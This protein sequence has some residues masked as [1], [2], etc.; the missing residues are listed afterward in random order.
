MTFYFYDLET[1]GLNPFADRIMQ[2]GGQKVNTDLEPLGDL[3]EFYVKLSDD[4]LPG[5]QAIMLHQI[6]PQTA[7][8]EGLSEVQFLKWL[9]ENV[10]ESKTIFAGYN[11]LNFDNQFMRWLHWRNFAPEAPMKSSGRSLDIYALMRLASDLR[12]EGLNWPINEKTQQPILVL[13]T[14]A[15][16]NKIDTSQSHLAGSDVVITL[17]LG[18]LI[19]KAQ[20]KLFEHYL[21]LLQPDFVKQILNHQS[22]VFTYS[23]PFNLAWGA[24]TTLATVL[25]EHPTKVNHYIIYDLR[26]DPQKWVTLDSYNLDLTL[27]NRGYPQREAS[28]FQIIDINQATGDFTR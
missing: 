8:L 11:I 13:S 19:K 25:A 18:R 20:P 24:S 12:P 22:G 4:I 28:P 1:T 3:E 7:N 17:A 27:K 6:L 2:F 21:S 23:H 26:C 5:P 9:Y 10:Y 16:A 15:Q 14:L